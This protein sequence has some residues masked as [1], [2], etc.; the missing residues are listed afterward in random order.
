MITAA[1]GERRIL[2]IPVRRLTPIFVTC[3]VVTLLVQCTGTSVAAT[4]NWKGLM[5]R[6][7]SNILIGGLAAQTATLAFF[8]L[9][10][11]NFAGSRL[12]VGARGQAAWILGF[13]SAFISSVMIFVGVFLFCVRF[14]Y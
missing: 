14:T 13:R 12:Y 7:G 9:V 6:T 10:I 8:I 11:S 5:A 1:S 4:Q 2:Y 3:D